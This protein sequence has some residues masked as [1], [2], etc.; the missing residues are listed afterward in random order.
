MP[1]NA[2]HVL[3]ITGDSTL[4]WD[5]NEAGE[6][7]STKQLFDDLVKQGYKIF[8]KAATKEERVEVTEFDAALGA[9]VVVPKMK[10][11]YSKEIQSCQF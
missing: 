5:P 2:F 6:V 1:K 10:G 11:G 3:D 8:T 4:S 7:A 9:L